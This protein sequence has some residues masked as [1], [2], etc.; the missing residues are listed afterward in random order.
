KS[1][2]L[3]DYSK[4]KVKKME[5]LTIGIEEEYQI[6]DSETRELTSYI[7]EFLNRGAMLFRDQV[8]PE[9][10]QSQVEIGSQV[11]RNI[12]EA[13]QEITRLRSVVIDVAQ[14]SGCK[15]VAAGTHPFSR[16]QDQIITDKDRYKGLI[17]NMQ[18]VA[19]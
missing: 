3:A 11:C 4:G 14:E 12:R 19:Q 1:Q 15:I 5:E 17:T 13:R 7:S 2:W 18:M 6:I 16:W 9:F 10:M 8:K